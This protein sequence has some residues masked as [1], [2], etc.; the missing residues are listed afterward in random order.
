M[1]PESKRIIQAKDLTEKQLQLLAICV[2]IIST[3]QADSLARTA[4][5][6]K[7]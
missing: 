2:G 6:S 4:N 5:P 7:T 3:L 1:N